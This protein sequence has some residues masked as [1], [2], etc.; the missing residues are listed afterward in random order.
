MWRTV[1]R[2]FLSRVAHHPLRRGR[3]MHVLRRSLAL[4]AGLLAFAACSDAVRQPLSPDGHD[5]RMTITTSTVVCPD[6]VSVGQTAQCV[7]YFYDEN[8]NLVS[9]ATPT[10]S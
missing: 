3:R 4:T 9:N 8:H 5:P 1:Q 10:W 6:T 2:I 7:A